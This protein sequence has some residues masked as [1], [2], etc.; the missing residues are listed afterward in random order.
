[1]TT[2]NGFKAVIFDMDGVIVNSMPFHF[3]AW[4][5]VFN[6]LS[7]YV[8]KTDLYMREGEKG[9]STLKYFCN[10]N[11]F[12][13]SDD[14]I[15]KLLAEKE[16]RFNDISKPILFTIITDI[17]DYL[18]VKKI[19]IALVTG[20]S[21]VEVEKLL[22][23]DLFDSFSVMIT[24]D[25]VKKGKPDP[26]PYLLASKKLGIKPKK[27]L[28]I[29]NAPF[30]IKSAK[31]AGMICYAICTSLDKNYLKDADMIFDTFDGLMSHIKT[32]SF[33]GLDNF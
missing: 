6:K 21:Y 5:Y 3:E 8:I 2:K 26:E 22:D 1:M 20:T 23:Q 9:D 12:K 11:N 17:I 32:I 18:K 30:G 10:K 28:V 31:D 4:N 15:V 19:P 16:K 25:I 7:F 29:E 14:D 13:I 33:H 27:C 24:G